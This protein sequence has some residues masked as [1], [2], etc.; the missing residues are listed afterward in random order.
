ML[1]NSY[2][3]IAAFLPACLAGFAVCAR[4]GSPRLT[5]ALLLAASLFYYGYWDSQYLWL[6][7]GSVIVNYGLALAIAGARRRGRGA[8]LLLS[9]GIAA[10]LAPLAF[11]KYAGFALDMVGSPQIE[12]TLPALVLPLGISFYTFQQ[13]AYLVDVRRGEP[14]ERSFLGYALFVTFFPQLI[15]GPIVHYKEMLPQF[16]RFGRFGLRA[17]DLSIGLTI[18]AIG[19]FKKTV[20]ADSVAG[21]STPIYSA[22]A[23]GDPIALLDGWCAALG[24]GFQLYFD[25]SAYSDMAIGVGH[26]FGIKLPINFHAPYRAASIVDFW[27][28]W[29]MTLSRFLRDFV[30]IPFGGNRG[31]EAFRYRNIM[32]TML[33]GGLWHGAGWTFVLWGGIHGALLVANHAW[34]RFVGW[35]PSGPLGPWAGRVLTFVAIMAAWVPFRADSFEATLSIWRGMAG[36]NGIELPA[37]LAAII[38]PAALNGMGIRLTEVPLTDAVLTWLGLGALCLWVWFLP[39]PY[40]LLRRYSPALEHDG[41]SAR[42]ASRPDVPAARALIWRATPAWAVGTSV[43]AACGILAML[44]GNSEFL[45]YRF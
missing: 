9:V 33:I 3:F 24:Y 5:T 32:L 18:F 23:A 8:G 15:A 42:F 1:F 35:W 30:Y 14:A 12:T 36:L 41:G 38:S 7:I 29:H 16:R 27:R 39:T 19:L 44:V 28:R 10:N 43:V 17:S 34:R 37:R 6:I 13:I 31:G 4:L 21:I 11:Y 22:A 40:M 25:F 45:Y 20:I 2:V 26:M